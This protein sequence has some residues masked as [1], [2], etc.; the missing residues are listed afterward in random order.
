MN[1][2]SERRT[3]ETCSVFLNRKSSDSAIGSQIRNMV[4]I[5]IR[6][7]KSAHD[8]ELLSLPYKSIPSPLFGKFWDPVDCPRNHLDG[9]LLPLY[10]LKWIR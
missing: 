5:S 8:P 10:F 7:K 3:F 9:R 1:T 6:M 4:S 2:E